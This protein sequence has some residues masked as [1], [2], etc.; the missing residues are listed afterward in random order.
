M[1][2]SNSNHF[3]LQVQNDSFSPAER[4]SWPAQ[5]PRPPSRG[6]TAFWSSAGSTGPRTWRT[7]PSSWTPKC[8]AG[9]AWKTPGDEDYLKINILV[10]GFKTEDNGSILK[11]GE[12]FRLS[13][14]LQRRLYVVLLCVTIWNKFLTLILNAILKCLFFAKTREGF[15]YC[16]G[17]VVS[18]TPAQRKLQLKGPYR[19]VVFKKAAFWCALSFHSTGFVTCDGRF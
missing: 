2:T 19:V 3:G 16:P 18:S 8:L 17:L 15:W 13:P 7:C 1:L 11:S 9:F 12:R 14:I 6:S 4:H 10:D 5:S